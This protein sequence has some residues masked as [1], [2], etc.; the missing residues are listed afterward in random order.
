MAKAYVDVLRY[1]I[2]SSPGKN[3][4]KKLFTQAVINVCKIGSRVRAY[5]V[6]VLSKVLTQCTTDA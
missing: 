2:T 4:D 3:L 1:L 6:N 5:V